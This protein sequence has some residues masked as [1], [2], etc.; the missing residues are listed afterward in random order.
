MDDLPLP[1]RFLE[2]EEF[3][4]GGVEGDSQPHLRLKSSTMNST[5]IVCGGS[6]L[7][8]AKEVVFSTSKL[9]GGREGADRDGYKISIT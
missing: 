2:M 6:L 7:G 9:N 5:N 3:Y 1:S 4:T 8:V